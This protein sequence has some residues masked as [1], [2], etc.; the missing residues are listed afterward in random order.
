[1][2]HQHDRLGTPPYLVLKVPFGGQMPKWYTQNT[3]QMVVVLFRANNA[4]KLWAGAIT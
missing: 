1:M 3:D 4:E 2:K